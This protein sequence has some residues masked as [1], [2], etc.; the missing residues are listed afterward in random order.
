M[1]MFL[2]VG[3]GGYSVLVDPKSIGLINKAAEPESKRIGGRRSRAEGRVEGGWRSQSRPVNTSQVWSGTRYSTLGNAESSAVVVI[4]YNTCIQ[5]ELTSH[6]NRGVGRRE[7]R[8]GPG[9]G[10]RFKIQDPRSK[11][12]KKQQQARACRMPHASFKLYPVFHI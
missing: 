7:K 4:Q 11:L 9:P 3:G 12:L 6:C 10:P 1:P 8:P 2:D 5:F